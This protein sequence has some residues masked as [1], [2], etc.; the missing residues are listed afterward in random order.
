MRLQIL[1]TFIILCLQASAQ[2]TLPKF[3][4][5][6]AKGRIVVAF[7]NPF[8]NA[9]Q[10]NIERSFDSVH[11]FTTINALSEPRPGLVTFRDAKAPNVHMYYRIFIQLSSGYSFTHADTPVI[12]VEPPPEVKKIEEKAIASPATVITTAPPRKPVWVPSTHVFTDDY[13]NV[14]VE[15]PI[16]GGK[17]Y[18]LKFFDDQQHFLFG[19]DSLRDVPLTIDKSNFLHSG[20]FNFEFYIDG[21]LEEKNKFL[22]SKEN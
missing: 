1:I 19:M 14:K 7:Y 22:L 16:P 21:K 6:N 17:R 4:V 2:D 9:L 13:G 18:T 15:Y 11:N 20:W 12:F 10:V 3:Q 5:L 8:D